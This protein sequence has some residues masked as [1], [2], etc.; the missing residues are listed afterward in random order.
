[1][2]L[3]PLYERAFVDNSTR[4]LVQ[5]GIDVPTQERGLREIRRALVADGPLSRGDLVDRLLNKGIVLD[6][7]TRLHMFRL[8]IARGIACLGPDA[9]SQTCLALAR[10]W[11][12]EPRPQQRDAALNELARRYLRA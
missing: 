12:G 10:D 1:A 3:V 9:G 4:R 2:W 7:S 5:L 11:L 6:P 8:A